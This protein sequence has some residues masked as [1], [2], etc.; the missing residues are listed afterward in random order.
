[1]VRSESKNGESKSKG[2]VRATGVTS[3]KS[4]DALGVG[5]R[6]R[7]RRERLVLIRVPQPLQARWD[8]LQGDRLPNTFRQMADRFLVVE[9]NGKDNRNELEK[10]LKEAHL[11]KSVSQPSA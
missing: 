2:G 7:D 4:Q 10:T 6:G 1:M 9:R 5:R 8:R 3:R 11:C